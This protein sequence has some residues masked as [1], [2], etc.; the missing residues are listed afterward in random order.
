MK[1]IKRDGT[2][3]SYDRNKI[4]I[5]IQKANAEV[6]PA[7]KVTDDTIEYITRDGEVKNG[8]V[9]FQ[10]EHCSDYF[11]TAAIVN[12]AVNNPKSVNFIII[13]LIVVVFILIAVT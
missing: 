12:D 7:E 1:V 5:A 4:K 11:L 3:V 9:E 13:G 10:I 6:E 8:Y 2:T